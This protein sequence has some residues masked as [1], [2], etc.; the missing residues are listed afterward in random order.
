MQLERSQGRNQPEMQIGGGGD[1][2]FSDMSMLQSTKSAK[3][4]DETTS[5]GANADAS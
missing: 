1:E 5:V 2:R 3:Q 4:A